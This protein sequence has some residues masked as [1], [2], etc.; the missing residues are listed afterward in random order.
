VP[1][2][3]ARVPG[4]RARR[5]EALRRDDELL[6]APAEPAADD[7]LGP[8]DGGP[9]AAERIHVGGVEERDAALGGPVHDR[10]GSRFVALEPEGHRPEADARDL[11]AG[12]A[13]SYVL[14]LPILPP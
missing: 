9:V 11:E 14:H 13:E 3:V 7:L 6:A 1:A 2:T 10:D 12:P 5:P 8:P 4:A